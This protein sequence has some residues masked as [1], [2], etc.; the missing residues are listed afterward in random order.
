MHMNHDLLCVINF[1]NGI[2]FY[3]NTKRNKVIAKISYEEI[4]YVMGS[5]DTLKIGYIN[6]SH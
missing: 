2:T 5:S 1:S 6:T 4:L 3:E